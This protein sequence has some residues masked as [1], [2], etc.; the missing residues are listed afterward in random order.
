ML[1]GEDGGGSSPFFLPLAP[2]SARLPPLPQ[3]VVAIAVLTFFQQVFVSLST[4]DSFEILSFVSQDGPPCPVCSSSTLDPS[5][6]PADSMNRQALKLYFFSWEGQEKSQDL[7]FPSRRVQIRAVLSAEMLQ[8]CVFFCFVICS[9]AEK[10]EGIPVSDCIFLI[11]F[12][13]LIHVELAL[14]PEGE[15]S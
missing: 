7:G 9:L 1:A 12:I 6:S 15:E 2:G 5:S 8:I 10:V 13:F 11:P 3:L 14:L 4:P